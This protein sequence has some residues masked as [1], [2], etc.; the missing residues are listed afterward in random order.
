MFNRG[1]LSGSV[2]H[3]QWR[4]VCVIADV[5]FAEFR[6]DLVRVSGVVGGFDAEDTVG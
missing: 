2:G 6:F 1:V 3:T 4:G 5:L